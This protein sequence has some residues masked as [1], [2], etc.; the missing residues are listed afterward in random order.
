MYSQAPLH[1]GTTIPLVPTPPANSQPVPAAQMQPL[2][3]AD[4]NGTPTLVF[5]QVYDHL[6]FSP[7]GYLPSPT[8]PV[9]GF[10]GASFNFPALDFQAPLTPP[11]SGTFN[12]AVNGQQFFPAGIET[13][14]QPVLQPLPQQ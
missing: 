5:G 10:G 11:I 12:G 2:Y 13:L 1:T 14:A 9:N 3:I 7:H 6:C 8:T 4:I